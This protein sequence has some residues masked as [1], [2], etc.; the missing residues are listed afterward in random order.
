[1]EIT[2]TGWVLLAVGLACLHRPFWLTCLLLGSVTFSATAV[3]NFPAVPF[4][5]QPYHWFGLLLVASTAMLRLPQFLRHV[6]PLAGINKTL[7]PFLVWGIVATL[8]T[9]TKGT[10]V[11]HMVH[12]AFGT[13]VMICVVTNTARWKDRE[14]AVRA[15]VAGNLFAAGWGIFALVCGVTGLPYPDWIFNN[16]EGQ[17]VGTSTEMFWGIPRLASVATEPSYLV[18]SLVPTLCLLMGL[19]LYGLRTKTAVPLLRPLHWKAML[20]AI[21]AL[22]S[23]SS[24]GIVALAVASLGPLFWAKRTRKYIVAIYS[25]GAAFIAYLYLTN[26]IVV[27]LANVLLFGKLEYGSGTDRIVSVADA[28]EAF[29]AHPIFGAGPGLITSHDLFLKLLSNF[30]VVGAMF[31]VLAL[32]QATKR[33]IHTLKRKPRRGSEALVL[34]LIAANLML[35]LMDALAGVSYQYG[36]FWALLGLL[37][38]ASR[39]SRIKRASHAKVNLAEQPILATQGVDHYHRAQ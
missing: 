4:G 15:L 7:F 12:L 23:T 36:I 11:A 26:P 10:S 39:P 38:S 28:S 29:A 37:V 14:T 6:S 17:F 16:S 13:C 30:G 21:V 2:I 32:A 22:L 9:G 18:R 5:L 19:W 1:M 24:L 35:W 27:D 34:G 31:F 20:L 3:A 33:G 8:A 25:V